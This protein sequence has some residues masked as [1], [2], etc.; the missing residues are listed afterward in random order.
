MDSPGTTIP[1]PY[2]CTT[3]WR[4]GSSG[5][6]PQPP[7]PALQNPD[8]GYLI[9]TL[10][11]GLHLGAPRINTFSSKTMPGETKVSLEQWNHEIQ[12]IKDQDPE[13][14]VQEST[15]KSLKEAAADMA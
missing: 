12:Y 2:T 13:S 11:L 1:I 5:T 7:L 8:M 9:N 15:V 6:T 14:V 4:M 3:R 10:A